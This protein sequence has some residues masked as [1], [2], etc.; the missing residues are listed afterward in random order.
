MP[1]TDYYQSLGVSK[2]ASQ[3]EI[4]KAY[5]K[6][7][8]KYHP[9]AQPDDKAAAA[10]FKEIQEAFD[11]LGDADKRQHYDRFGTAGPGPGGG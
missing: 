10:K 5:R 3:D 8:K 11:I 6:L 7:A 1:V 9:D 4:K 2:G